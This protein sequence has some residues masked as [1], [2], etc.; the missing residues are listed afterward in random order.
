[1]S[2]QMLCQTDKNRFAVRPADMAG[3]WK[4]GKIRDD[5]RHTAIFEE[6]SEAE[7]FIKHKS[8]DERGLLLQLPEELEG[9]ST[10]ALQYAIMY[11]VCLVKYGVTL[12][13][14]TLYNAA[15]LSEQ[16]GRAYQRGRQDE[17]EKYQRMMEDN[18]EH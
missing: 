5:I 4:D 12:S 2:V 9:T 7:W 16:L 8:L 18:N 14:E 15:F 13:P 11:G 3:V 10:E 6:Q 17:S 1:M